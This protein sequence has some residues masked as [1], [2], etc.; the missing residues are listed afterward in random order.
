SFT[1]K[2]NSPSALAAY[3]LAALNIPKLRA[4]FTIQFDPYAAGRGKIIWIRRNGGPPLP[5]LS[6]LASI[7]NMPKNVYAG[8]PGHVARLLNR[9]AS[10]PVRN[11]DNRFTWVVVHA[12][13]RFADPGSPGVKLGVYDAAAYCAGHLSSSIKVVTPEQLAKL[14]GQ[15]KALAGPEVVK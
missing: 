1:V 4:L 9:W 6:A 8:S 3:R 15:A 5:V 14:L 13:S 10:K 2:W 12:W 11:V 7:W